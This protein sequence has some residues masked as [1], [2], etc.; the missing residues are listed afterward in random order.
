MTI[1]DAKTT[2]TPSAGLLGSKYGKPFVILFTLIV[3]ALSGLY[4][5]FAWNRYNDEAS[6][7]AIMLA[8]SLETLLQH[9]QIAALSGGAEDLAK[10]E[11]NMTKLSLT[12]LVGSKNPIEFAYLMGEQDGKIVFL[13]DSESPESLDYS[14]PGQVYEEADDETWEP[15]KSGKTILSEPATDRWGT[16]ISALVPIKDPADGRVIAVLGLDY[17]ASEWY[18]N[19]WQRMIPD[20]IIVLCALLL[21]FALLYTWKQNLTLKEIS[22]KLSYSEALYRSVFNQAPI[23]IAILNDKNFALRSEFEHFS[24]NPMF[25]QI[26]GRKSQ[27]LDN[28]QW[29]EI[30]HPEDLKTDLDNFEQFKSNKINAYSMEKR[31]LK[32]DGS[33]V[34]TNMKVSHLQGLPDKHSMHICLLEDISLRKATEDSLTESERSK[35]VLLANLPGLAYR[36]NYDSDWTMQ[37][38]SGGCYGLTGYAPESLLNNKELSFND[39][40]TP[41]YRETLSKEWVRVL[42]QRLP[43]RHE[44]EII[45]A[46]GEKKWVIEMGEGIFDEHG[47]VIALEGI[48][49]DISKRKKYENL[50]VYNNEH[51]RWTGLYN[52]YYLENLLLLD[53]RKG[54]INKRALVCI[55]M[56]PLQAITKAYGF[57]Y[58]QA[59]IKK[60]ADML[61]RYCTNNHLLFNTYADRFV[62]YLKEYKDKNELHMFCK[63]LAYTLESVLKPEKGSCAIGTIEF[64]PE[65]NLNADLLLKKVLIASEKALDLNDKDFNICFYDADMEVQVMREED[66]KH[67]LAQIAD[68][69]NNGRLFLQYQPIL[70]LKSN[71]ICGFEA[72]ARLRSDK[73]GMVPPL[74]FISIAEKTRLIVP[75]GQEI[76]KQAFLFL[77]KLQEKGYG[78]INVS[79]NVST[80]QMLRDDFADNLFKTINEMQVSPQNIG[81]ELTESVFSANYEEINSIIGKLKEAGIHTAIDDFGTGYSS[82]AK[83]RELNVN[84]L[85]IDKY[86][87]DELLEIQPEKAVTSDI[88][89]M[90]HK[91]GHCVVAEGVEHE[92]QKQ[93]LMDYGCDKIQG[94]LISRPLD[95]QA[96]IEFLQNK[97]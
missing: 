50:L 2:E 42:A 22:K 8:Q 94:Y 70:D 78:T 21:F 73:L 19:L 15:F 39:L 36:C 59:L 92:T 58:T 86:F 66:I 29:T 46:S 82:I 32:P 41:E 52:R 6:T 10:P 65:E 9:Q 34:W 26:T 24:I 47:Q 18:A 76:M 88:I 84:C 87:I 48:V 61:S 16:W 7:K 71:S 69:E 74:E 37:Y 12:R 3:F 72:L 33:I 80:I 93:Y 5:R 83:E 63:D 97:S 95:E 31:F 54:F 55:N 77:N 27:E 75:L 60:T 44:Y 28:I 81:L 4:L 85:K 49:F 11:Y 20:L 56:S 23:G 57:N 67:E 89:S 35:S 38:V 14:P 1:R 45:T 51:D 79:I 91:M 62:F 17:A 68:G 30:T 43:F 53:A 40:I 25:E 96:A 13:I 64:A 90:A